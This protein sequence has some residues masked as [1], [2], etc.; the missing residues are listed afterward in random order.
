MPNKKG[1][2]LIELLVVVLII[3]I[4]AAIALPNYQR[5]VFKSRMKTMEHAMAAMISA[6]Q[7]FSITNPGITHDDIPQGAL[8][9][10][11]PKSCT[12]RGKG[13]FKCKDFSIY[14]Y[15]LPQ[16]SWVLGYHNKYFPT[17]S[18]NHFNLGADGNFVCREKISQ[19]DNLLVQYCKEMGY[20]IAWG[21]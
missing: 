17:G 8:I 19:K 20:K 16:K 4:L 5:A 14:V 15:P 2:T 18:Y 12:D 10:E 11:M 1:F 9:V 21:E 3:G 6:T 13:E 7:L